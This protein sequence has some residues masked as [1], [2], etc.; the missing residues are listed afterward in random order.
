MGQVSLDRVA[1]VDGLPAFAGKERMAEA[2][3][4]PGG[5]IATAARAAARL[6]LRV[7]LVTSVGDDGAG[8]RALAPV[9]EEGV[10]LVAVKRVAGASSQL[11]FILVDRKSGERT[12]LWHRDPRLSLEIG[13]V[14]ASAVRE[15]RL[16]HLDAGDPEAAAAAAGIA[17]TAGVPVLLDA[18]TFAPGLEPLLARVDYPIVSREFAEAVGGPE[19]ALEM[20]AGH[21]AR[22][23]VVT[24]GAEGCLGGPPP[25]RPSPGLRTAVHDTTGAGD[26]FHAA[27][28]WALLEG[29]SA[30]ETMRAA[31]AAAAWSCRALGA[32]GALP[33]RAELRRLLDAGAPL[34]A[35]AA[36]AGPGRRR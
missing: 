34:G 14:P 30:A 17:R 7:G 19:A 36:Q 3:E 11:A 10:E 25:G 1:V 27:F 8:D 9:A 6:G 12:V 21:G 32:Q 20:L 2:L 16:L 22:F 23:P 29:L 24:L 26:V 5:Q 4:L 33:T 13:D 35:P 18:D 15:A 28:A 31:N